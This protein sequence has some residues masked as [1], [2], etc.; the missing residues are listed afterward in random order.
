M[1]IGFCPVREEKYATRNQLILMIGRCCDLTV[2]YGA[3]DLLRQFEIQTMCLLKIDTPH[4]VLSV[5]MN[6]GY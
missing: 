1:W 6:H 5:A 2:S 3:I 4:L